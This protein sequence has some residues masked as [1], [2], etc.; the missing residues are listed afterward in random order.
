M[1]SIK[2]NREF[3]NVFV[4]DALGKLVFKRENLAGFPTATPGF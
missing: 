4:E 3:E 2:I 1:T